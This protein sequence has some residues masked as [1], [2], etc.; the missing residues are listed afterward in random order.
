MREKETIKEE[1]TAETAEHQP[2]TIVQSQKAHEK[3]ETIHLEMCLNGS[4]LQFNI[5]YIF[6][7]CKF[8]PAQQLHVNRTPNINNETK[9]IESKA[10]K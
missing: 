8:F 4:I 3:D 9:R 6:E 1:W 7:S 10:T 2:T 5:A